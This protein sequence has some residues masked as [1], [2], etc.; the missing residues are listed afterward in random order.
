MGRGRRWL[1]VFGFQWA[2]LEWFA[3]LDVHL[4]VRVWGLV[5]FGLGLD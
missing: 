4:F 2:P 3:G 1:V 5:L